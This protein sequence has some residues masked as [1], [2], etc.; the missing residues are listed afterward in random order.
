MLK[1]KSIYSKSVVANLYLCMANL[2]KLIDDACDGPAALGIEMQTCV[3][4]GVRHTAHGH[5][6]PASYL[7]DDLLERLSPLSSTA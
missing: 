5:A 6:V 1:L 3:D 7:I 2:V 4:I